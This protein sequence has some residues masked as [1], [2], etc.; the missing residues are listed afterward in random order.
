MAFL[1]P[2]T[3]RFV[4]P[5]TR[6]FAGRLPWFGI[7]GYVGRRSG[8]GYRTPMNVFRVGDGYVFALTYGADVDWVKNV[9][10]AGEAE[11]TTRGRTMRLVEPE[12]VHDP[13]RRLM[14][15][16]VRFFLGLMRVHDFLR[17]TRA[18][19]APVTTP[20]SEPPSR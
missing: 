1:R 5:I 15:Q 20:R 17:M 10:A 12:L 19:G 13:S 11:L 9:L 16:P 6:R 8:R 2:F 3:L 4:N 14:P 7:I 18:A